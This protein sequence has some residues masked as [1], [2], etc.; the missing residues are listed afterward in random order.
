MGDRNAVVGISE[1]DLNRII[2]E[3]FNVLQPK[4]FFNFP[5]QNIEKVKTTVSI[6]IDEAPVID[7]QAR[8][9][10][11]RHCKSQADQE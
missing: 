2:A 3:L 10:V 9:T 4:G 5:A 6:T 11:F 8:V 1:A 7:L